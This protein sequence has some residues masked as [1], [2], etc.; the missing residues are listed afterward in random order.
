MTTPRTTP[1]HLPCGVACAPDCTT[2]SFRKDSCLET[3]LLE[4]QLWVSQ[5]RA[6]TRTCALLHN[7]W[8]GSSRLSSRLVMGPNSHPWLK[9]F[10]PSSFVLVYIVWLSLIVQS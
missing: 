10:W 9:I 1:Q 7:Y 6:A 4:S 5:Q 8:G 2:D 3:K